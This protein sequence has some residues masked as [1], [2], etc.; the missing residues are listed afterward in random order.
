MPDLERILK[1]ED[2]SRRCGSGLKELRLRGDWRLTAVAARGGKSFDALSS[3]LLRS[4][5]ARLEI[6]AGSDDRGLSLA[7][8]IRLGA[9]VLRFV[10]NGKLV[11]KRPLLRFR[12]D[13]LQLWLGPWK[14]AEISL[15]QPQQRKAPFFALIASEQEQ[16][17]ATGQ[18]Q[19]WMAAR[20]RS[21]G[22]AV[23]YRMDAPRSHASAND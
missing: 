21:G 22:I 8:S 7:N 12:F 23:W 1:L 10:G 18:E 20:G 9:L 4:F 5:G 13:R 19:R 15:A 6:D 2:Q 14:S 3:A 16:D 11:G 17:P